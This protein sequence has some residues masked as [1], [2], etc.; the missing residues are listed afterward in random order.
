M[1]FFF[2]LIFF[3]C[4][5]FVFQVV[6]QNCFLICFCFFAMFAFVGETNIR[7]K[8]QRKR[9]TTSLV[10]ADWSEAATP[11]RFKSSPTVWRVWP[12]LCWPL[13]FDRSLCVPSGQWGC[14]V[15]RVMGGGSRGWSLQTPTASL[16]SRLLT[17]NPC[18]LCPSRN[19]KMCSCQSPR[20]GCPYC[21]SSLCP[22]FF[23]LPLSFF[24]PHMERW[25]SDY[26]Q[27]MEPWQM[28]PVQFPMPWV[29]L[30][31]LFS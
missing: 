15:W 30:V 13:R 19:N 29:T 7:V 10:T 27:I 26:G 25:H 1:V 20:D 28:A 8:T 11:A 24:P 23:F 12:K 22:E 16:S 2:H 9:P 17:F 5:C 21:T 31:N 4:I 6:F 3:L 14:E 18:C